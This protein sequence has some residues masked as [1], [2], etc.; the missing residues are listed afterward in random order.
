[1]GGCPSLGGDA[2]STDANTERC[3]APWIMG[4]SIPVPISELILILL[5]QLIARGLTLTDI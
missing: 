2:V 3:L 5:S 4:L 1:M